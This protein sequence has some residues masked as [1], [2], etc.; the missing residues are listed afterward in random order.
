MVSVLCAVYTRQSVRGEADLTSCEVQHEMCLRFA[1]ARGLH[2]SSERFDDEGISGATPERPALQRLLAGIRSGAWAIDAVVVH[3]LDRLSRRVRDCSELLEEF[4]ACGVRLFI[5]AMPELAGGAADTLML[6]ILSAFAEFERD[7]IA[8]RIR[9]SRTGLVARGRRIAGVTPFGYA[10]D[11]RTKQLAPVAAEVEVVRE[12]FRLIAAGVLPREVARLAEEPGW[13]TRGDRQWTARQVLDMVSN[14]VYVSRFRTSQGTRAGTHAAIVDEDLFNRCA[15][16]IAE[17]RT[18]SPGGR[19]HRE[20]SHLAGKV[21]CARCGRV[22]SIRVT[23]N[24]PRRY[25]YFRCRAAH[26][27]GAPCTGTQVRAFDIEETVRSVL[28][29]P[30]R[31]FPHKRG[32]PTRAAVALYSLGQVLPLLDP[33]DE[34][35]LIRRVVQEIAWNADSQGVRLALDL[36]ALAEGIPRPVGL[37]TSVCR[38]DPGYRR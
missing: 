24:G 14:P 26:G 5:V 6:N 29:E 30:A 36:K 34:R 20:W 4:K 16:V 23:A 3:R 21:R 2:V 9:D 27:G 37:A 25:V 13:K 35:E 38:L 32:R 7:M 11:R 22:M 31:A 33:N 28:M 17:R 15:A 10:S 18:S 1:K 19:T 12:F 8:S